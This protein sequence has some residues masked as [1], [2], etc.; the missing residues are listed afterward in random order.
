[1]TQLRD[2]LNAQVGYMLCYM[3]TIIKDYC[4]IMNGHVS[5]YIVA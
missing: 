4:T 3:S 2:E 5:L 1:M